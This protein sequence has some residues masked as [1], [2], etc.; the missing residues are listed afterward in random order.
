MPDPVKNVGKVTAGPVT[1]KGLP[2]DEAIALAASGLTHR[3]ALFDEARRNGD[4]GF[5]DE[6]Y[7]RMKSEMPDK[8]RKAMAGIAGTAAMAATLPFGGPELAEGGSIL[9]NIAKH[10]G[11]A[12]LANAVPGAISGIIGGESKGGIASQ[13]ARSG[14]IGAGIGA[15]VAG[16]PFA[17]KAA[18]RIADSGIGGKAVSSLNGVLDFANEHAN[19]GLSTKKLKYPAPAPDLADMI[20]VEHYSRTP[21]LRRLDPSFMGE[22][23]PG[24][25]LA[26]SDRPDA[27]HVYS[28]EVPDRREVQFAKDYRYTG[29][30][31]RNTIYD[32]SADPLGIRK[33]TSELR[34]P[35]TAL[36]KKLIE[37]GWNGYTAGDAYGGAPHIIKT[38]KPL[39]VEPGSPVKVK[40][41]MF[42]APHPKQ[43]LPSGDWALLT[44]ENAGGKT[45]D[46]ATNAA[47]NASLEDHLAGKGYQFTPVKGQYPQDGKLLN[48]NSYL[49]HDI[50]VPDAKA[51]GGHYS[52]HGVVTPK[53]YHVL[54]DNTLQPSRGV[55]WTKGDTY[56]QFHSGQ[57]FASDIDWGTLR[58]DVSPKVQVNPVTDKVPPSRIPKRRAGAV[59]DLTGIGSGSPF[60][61]NKVAP[62]ESYLY[63]ATNTDNAG[64]IAS[65][66]KLDVHAPD[67]GT[68]QD[69]WPDGGTEHRA[70]FSPNEK[71]A[72][73]FAP[74]NGAPAILR[75]PRSAGTFAT[76]SGTGD[77]ISRAPIAAEHIQIKT[78]D[79]WKPLK[80]PEMRSVPRVP[81]NVEDAMYSAKRNYTKALDAFHNAIS[82]IGIAPSEASQVRAQ[83]TSDA[84]TP[85]ALHAFVSGL[86]NVAPDQA[87]QL[88]TAAR[89]LSD[90]HNTFQSL[91]S[92]PDFTKFFSPKLAIAGGAGLGVA[93][94]NSDGLFGNRQ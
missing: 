31:P 88:G 93:S 85:D 54:A 23:R 48:E 75:V 39:N 36:E 77:V 2:R 61:P 30:I 25:E 42:G 80:H 26:R 7:A 41:K 20:P 62:S 87:Q 69:T 59:G 90:A 32:I 74:E 52:Q 4:T 11:M 47:R 91:R 55:N 81:G 65:S 10:A 28:Q 70:Y 57:K 13:A 84:T 56:S 94:A 3:A 33:A 82:S 40:G 72:G 18:S 71:T 9:A 49:V 38:F 58:P 19:P 22:G 53:G 12:G 60:K 73:Y 34:Q 64:D 89:D 17:A 5:I 24:R 46:A 45:M 6:V 16:L 8:R 63:H 29:Q 44:A 67:Y 21:N 78:P 27:L 92:H 86:G 14:A 35:A 79:G 50:S 76:E 66:G 68:D 43:D 1:P 83:V 51:I 37:N 15:G